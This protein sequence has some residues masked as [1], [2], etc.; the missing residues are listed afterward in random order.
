MRSNETHR[1]TRDP[2]ARL[3]RKGAG[4]EAK[5]GFI[6]HTLMENRSGLIVDARLKLHRLGTVRNFVCGRVLMG[7]RETPDAGTQKSYDS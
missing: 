3:Y 7:T 2:E 6:G 1:S 5:L 4:M